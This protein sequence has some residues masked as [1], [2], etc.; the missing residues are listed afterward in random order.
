VFAV[1]PITP[2][3]NWPWLLLPVL[4]L[5]AWYGYRRTTPP[6]VPRRRTV[7]IALRTVAYALL[8]IVLA[9][10]VWNRD[11]HTRERA[12]IAILVDESASMSTVDVAGGGSRLER[13]Q[14]A[15]AALGDALRDVPADLEVV[16]F[17]STAAAPE[18]LAD[19]VRSERGAVGP[20]TDVVGALAAAADRARS[21]NLQAVVLVSDGRPT[22]GTLDP[23][24]ASTGVPVFTVG[25][26]DTA[27]TR[28]LAIGRC[29]YSPVAYVDSEAEIDVR[30]E[31]AGFAGAATT[32]RLVQDGR[33]VHTTRV[34][35]ES[36]RGRAATRIPL[37]F[38]RAGRQRYRL[39]LDALAGE[40]TEINNT[41]ELSIEVLPNRIRVLLVAA[42]PDWDVGFWARTLRDDPNVRVRVVTRDAGGGWI[43]DDG[44]AFAFP[45]GADW[46]RDW[47]LY[48]LAATGP[49]LQGDAGRDLVAAVQRG[50]GLLVL[51]GRDGVLGEPAATAALG[52]ALPVTRDRARAPQYGHARARLSPQGRHHAA[53]AP[54]LPLADAG[55]ALPALAPILGQ[56]T[57]VAVRAGAQVLLATDGEPQ[58][59]LLVVGR[60]GEGQTAV[61]NGF[62]LWR[63]GV[64]ESEPVRAAARGMV[65]GLVRALT[66]PR[67]IEAV[68]L[69]ASKPV[70]ESGEAVDL[71]AHVLDAAL[72]PQAG[73][74]VQI[75]VRRLADGTAAGTAVA[76]PRAA[77]EY[78]TSLPGLPPGDYE[79][80][81][82]ARL[83]D[84]EVGR[85]R[86]RFTVD[87][88][89]V[90]F[91]DAR[92]DIEFLRELAA[93][94]GG[95]YAAPESMA[96][97]AR[98]LPVAPRDVV[99]RSE[100][101]VWNT[102]PV[103]V[104]FVLV[105]GAEW[106][107]RKRFGLL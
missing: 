84:R 20:G 13:A 65:G 1:L 83:G 96:E 40:R 88:Y 102:T 58:A 46:T 99:L 14:R 19:Y 4:A 92:Q 30:I 81:A 34:A 50:K 17:S 33:D 97:L 51:A 72:E 74:Q 95:R 104:L 62:P 57:G 77:G 5:V 15:V 44:R 56:W 94:S 43:G 106:L 91:A 39:V 73:A 64:A 79:A 82:T 52:T 60:H 87:A 98:A 32:L 100:V 36:E 54:L 31:H 75:E 105:L 3:S 22:R 28:D 45:R 7:L 78:A 70:Y 35:F 90:E 66:Q 21:G 24:Q 48:V 18:P 80:T 59:P 11:R 8:C 55:G 42:R 67:D 26:G 25:L 101:E 49:L 61:V 89:S 37:R 2:Q 9:S 86:V 103:F 47:D 16:P 107:L 27:G 76:E 23:A 53:T 69:T 10:P 38:T 29:E 93:R 68:Q 41:R 71:R 6:L 85:A 63:W 12:R